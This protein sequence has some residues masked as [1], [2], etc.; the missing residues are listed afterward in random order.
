VAIALALS[1]CAPSLDPDPR[2]TA[3]RLD[4]ATYGLF[5]L[6][7][8]D[9]DGDGLLD[10]YT[11]NHSGRESLLLNQG[12]FRFTDAF[13]QWGLDQDPGFPGLDVVARETVPDAPGLYVG[14]RGPDI[15]VRSHGLSGAKDAV[16]GTIELLSRV[17]ME[18]SEGFRIAV[19]AEELPSGAMRSLIR[20]SG[21]PEGYFAFRPYIHALPIT[22]K[23]NKGGGPER[24]FVGTRRVNP[25]ASEFVINMRDR[26]GMAWAD[27]NGDGLM[28]LF[29][30]RGGLRG[31]MATVPVRFWDELYVQGPDGMKDIGREV[32]LEKKGC[33][34]RQAAWVD[35]DGD[36]RLDIYVVCGRGEDR[37]PNQL[38][39]QGE[40]GHFENVAQSVGLALEPNGKFVWL[41]VDGDHDLDLMWAG[42]RELAWYENRGEQFERH[43]L[44]DYPRAHEVSGL[45]LG[46]PDSDGDQDILMVSTGGNLLLIHERR[47]LRVRGPQEW[48]LPARSSAAAWVDIDNDGVEEL[49][50]LPGGIY[51]RG[52]DG[53]YRRTGTLDLA[54]GPFSPWRLMDAHINW[55]DMNNDGY[56]DLVVAIGVLPKTSWWARALVKVSGQ[57]QAAKGA[58]KGRWVARIYEN[59][60][61]GTHWLQLRL[62]GHAGNRQ[63]IGALAS[64]QAGASRWTTGPGSAESSRYSQGHYR[65]YA[66]LGEQPRAGRLEIQWPDGET[67]GFEDLKADALIVVRH[68]QAPGSARP[69]ADNDEDGR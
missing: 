57:E 18:D 60:G 17:T 22:F 68:D 47:G 29:I 50:A 26:H 56:R 41:D 35:F 38:F 24:I 48:G 54:Q 4:A 40:D 33:P 49:Y 32:G 12:A 61:A 20:F 37:H 23:V 27:Y 45:R 43:H 52:E 59:T 14:W 58:L 39:R 16:T 13:S 55:A 2:F 31:T 3:H 42:R 36:G 65:L 15:V 19:T 7:V 10:V 64:L 28:D 11:A 6:G 53:R 8:V 34:G 5:D 67:Q 44:K 21:G 69:A 30:T 1:G 25:R 62:D 46:D 9:A 66:G 51:R 63:A